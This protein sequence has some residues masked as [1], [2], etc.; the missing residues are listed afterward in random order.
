MW[1]PRSRLESTSLGRVIGG[2]V[3]NVVDRLRRGAVTDFIDAHYAGWHWPTFN[4][5]DIGIVCGVALLLASSSRPERRPT[6]PSG[7][8][9]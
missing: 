1:R 8:D 7:A 4:V 5:A 2:A 6:A 9:A 3:G